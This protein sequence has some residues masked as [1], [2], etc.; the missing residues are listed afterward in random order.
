MIEIPQG[1]TSFLPKRSFIN[2]F[3]ELKRISPMEYEQAECDG[4]ISTCGKLLLGYL[5]KVRTAIDNDLMAEAD[6]SDAVAAINR[7]VP[8]SRIS[9]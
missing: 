1:A 5:A 6:I 9:N 7:V 3:S 4:V 2:C 8:Q